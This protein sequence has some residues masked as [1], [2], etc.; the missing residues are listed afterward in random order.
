MSSVLYFIFG[1]FLTCCLAHCAFISF[2]GWKSQLS[3]YIEALRSFLL[4]LCFYSF[5]I[6]LFHSLSFHFSFTYFFLYSSV[7]VRG[8]HLYKTRLQWKIVSSFM[9]LF[10]FSS[11]VARKKVR[12]TEKYCSNANKRKNKYE[13]SIFF[14]LFSFYLMSNKCQQTFSFF[15]SYL[16]FAHYTLSTSLHLSLIMFFD[17]SS[18][19]F[20]LLKTTS[21]NHKSAKSKKINSFSS[22]LTNDDIDVDIFLYFNF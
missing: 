8:F 17:S 19:S 10:F 16:L 1:S 15:F 12:K 11:S 7:D 2:H 22:K 9:H 13:F 4:L 18:S 14:I 21:I 3:V 20:S 5:K 6:F